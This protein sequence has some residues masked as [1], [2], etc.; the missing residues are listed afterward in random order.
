ML[1]HRI[2][3]LIVCVS[4]AVASLTAIAIRYFVREK[5]NKGKDE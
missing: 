2:I 5:K 3:G 1:D 4:I